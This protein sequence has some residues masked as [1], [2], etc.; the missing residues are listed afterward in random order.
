MVSAQERTKACF[1]WLQMKERAAAQGRAGGV[2][3]LEDGTAAFSIWGEIGA[4]SWKRRG[5]EKKKGGA[6]GQHLTY[7]SNSI[8]GNSSRVGRTR[9]TSK[10]LRGERV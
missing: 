9:R 8:P 10:R 4:S 6:Q 2:I 1:I 3:G 7:H 5:K